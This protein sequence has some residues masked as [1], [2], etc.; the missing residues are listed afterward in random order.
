M[1]LLGVV[2]VSPLN[3]YVGVFLITSCTLMLQIIQTRI[4]SVVAWYHLAFFAIS[5]AMFGITAGAVWVYL[6]RD[7]FSEKT[8]SYDL[9]YY[10]TAFALTTALCLIV[11]MTLSPIVTP[12][13]TSVWTWTELALFMSVPFFF[14]GIVV[15]LALTRSPF[16]I[17]RVYAV[18]LI[19]AAVGCLGVLLLLNSTD[20]P[21]AI[22][23]VASI[24]ATGA[25][26]FAR[27]AIGTAPSTIP[28]LDAIFRQR[29]IIILFLVCFSIGNGLSDY[30]FQPL[31]AKGRFEGGNSH[32]F[33]E[34]NTF[35]RIAVYPT[36]YGIPSM[37]GPSPKFRHN[38]VV[39]PQRTMNIDGDAGT[40][41]YRF[42]GNLEDVAFLKYDVTNLAYQLPGRK[43]AAIIGVG[44]GRDVLSAAVFGLRDITGVEVN[45]IFIKLLTEQPGFADFTNLTQLEGVKYI[46]DEGRSWFARTDQTFDIIQMSLTDTWAATGAGAFSLSENG[47]YTV[48]AWRIF[49]DRLS[50]RGV[51]TI[52]RWYNEKEPIETGRMLSLAVGAL[53]EMGM[54]E[55][56]RHIYLA[57]SGNIATLIVSRQPFSLG[58]LKALEDAVVFFEYKMLVSPTVE[59]DFEALRTIVA[60]RTREDLEDYTSRQAFD[61]TPATDDRPFFFNQLPL[62]KPIQAVHVAKSLVGGGGVGGVR[63]GNLVATVTLLILFLVSLGLVLA[64]IVVPLRPAIKDVGEK[65][66]FGGTLYFLLIGVGFMTVEIGLLQRMSVFLGHPIYS[67]SVLLFAL[68]LSTGLGSLLS[69]KLILDNR[70]K[71]AA[72]AL[73]TGA[74]I[75]ALPHW[76]PNVLWG[77]EGASLLTRA[78]VCMGAVAPAGLLMG[79][80][81]PAGMRLVSA[82][83]PKPTPWFWGING[84]A[85]VLASVVAVSTSIAVGIS[86]TLT[87]GAICYFLLVPTTLFLVW[88]RPMEHT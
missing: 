25:M 54:N 36:R 34:W 22:L 14:S 26:F 70:W 61:L 64:T 55:P 67:L 10:S 28:P 75:I 18:D 2:L 19:G 65:L 31:V 37:W 56:K 11:Q 57:T 41:A 17:G 45:P 72:W 66:V 82:I 12:S 74:Y 59:S 9:S 83:D 32:L 27:S 53:I 40:V 16:P 24:A 4:L 48:E 86:G 39:I 23:W 3:F 21:S 38:L 88:S 44:G 30:G 71:F 42:T 63:E 80:G 5:M 6:R 1:W 49:L 81:F 79:F 20:G 50:P 68:I 60:A 8:L 78:T 15:S 87:I 84:A 76:L 13:A 58:D 35:S 69:D 43:R 62:N 46:V 85:G 7:R 52:S 33:R 47:L 51:Y 77:F 29:K 73:M